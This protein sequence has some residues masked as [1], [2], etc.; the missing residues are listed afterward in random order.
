MQIREL[1]KEDDAVSPVI[2]VIL[3]VAIT[4]ILAAVIASFVLGLG[5]QADEVQPNS[6]FE[7][8]YNVSD[9]GTN[10]LTITLTDGDSILAEDLFLRGSLDD[11]T[12][13]LDFTSDGLLGTSG[14][15]LDSGYR[16]APAGGGNDQQ[17]ETVGGFGT[18]SEEIKS[19]QG[20]RIHGSG[21][22]GTELASY[23][24]DVVWDTGDDSATLAS[25]DGEA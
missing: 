24:L 10:D 15:S 12:I 20:V 2:G 1:F 11:N 19:G 4:V 23:D 3:M 8:N 7:F 25:D 13:D 22:S 17:A 9:A 6:N 5:D 16:D 14:D 18:S 21:T